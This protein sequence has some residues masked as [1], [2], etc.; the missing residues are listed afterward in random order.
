V[1]ACSAGGARGETGL[2]IA[3]NNGGDAHVAGYYR[4]GSILFSATT[5]VNAEPGGSLVSDAFVAK[6]D[7]ITGI[8]AVGD[9]KLI[10]VYPN[11]AADQ[12]TVTIPQ[13]GENV[14]SIYNLEGKKVFEAAT[15]I[16]KTVVNCRPL[17]PGIYFL[18]VQ[19]KNGN[20]VV[21]LAVQH[22]SGE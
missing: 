17:T 1:W 18:N 5:I 22:G 7:H 15:Q 13:S 6:L 19:T 11:P 10:S 16:E 14:I 3:V 21:K 20:E 9:G 12:F 4:S 8:E 2:S